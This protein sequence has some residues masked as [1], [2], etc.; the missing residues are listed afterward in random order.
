MTSKRLFIVLAGAAIMAAGKRYTEGDQVPLTERDGERLT[1]QG[2]VAPAKAAEPPKGNPAPS[3]LDGSV[4]EV[5][6]A[7][8][9]VAPEELAA[10]YQAETEGKARKGVLDAI[11]AAAK[12]PGAE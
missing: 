6:A 5:V 12:A 2:R 8:A 3:I 4:P 10:L 9:G 11:K 1:A 7:L